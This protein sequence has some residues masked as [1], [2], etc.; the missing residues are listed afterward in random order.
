MKTI[1]LLLP[2][3]LLTTFT[4][5]QQGTFDYKLTMAPNG[6]SRTSTSTLYFLNGNIRTDINITLPGMSKLIKQSMLILEKTPKTVYILNE[7]S[8]TYSET[9]TDYGK[10]APSG[11]VTVKVVGQEIIQKLNCTHSVVTSANGTM[12]VWTT[13]DIPGYEKLLSY[14]SSNKSFGSDNVLNALKKSGVDG[15]FVRMKNAAMTMD[16]VR[17]DTRPVAASLFEIPKDYKKR[18]FDPSALNNLTPAERKK[19]MEAFQKHQ[20]P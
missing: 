10:T 16:L 7:S 5:A 17:Y 11:K 14:W 15:F 6:Q 13:R 9:S 8:R 3:F 4:R 18:A 12:N 19:M 20:K 1:L 2:S